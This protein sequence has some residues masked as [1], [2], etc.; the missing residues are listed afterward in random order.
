MPIYLNDQ[1][2][3]SPQYPTQNG[4]HKRYAVP[5]PA[6]HAACAQGGDSEKI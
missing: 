3:M 1:S 2:P 4:S 5:D 6:A